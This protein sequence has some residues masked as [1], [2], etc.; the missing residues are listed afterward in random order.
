MSMRSPVRRSS[1]TR[2]S[3][4]IAGILVLFTPLALDG[5]PGAAPAQTYTTEVG[6]LRR[7]V[8]G[9]HA[10]ANLNTRTTL[11]VG[12]TPNRCDVALEAGEALFEIRRNKGRM[13]HVAAGTVTMTADIGAFSV[14]LRDSERVDVL[15]RKGTV[16][17]ASAQRMTLTAN[18]KARI[19][20]SGVTLE[21]LSE[22]D[23]QRLLGWTTGNLSFRGETL[24]E[25]VAELNR[26]N[27]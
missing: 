14:R 19:S 12:R 21:E 23:V 17:L 1:W 9:Q 24:E 2:A 6:E 11:I 25:V 10:V 16:T 15:V 8:L 7:V 3:F 27:S 18:Q 26:Y 22:A 20:P 5:S 4:F 13:L